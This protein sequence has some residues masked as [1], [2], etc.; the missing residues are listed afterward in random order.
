M[1]AP[2]FDFKKLHPG[3]RAAITFVIVLLLGL[4]GVHGFNSWR[5]Q[6][7]ELLFHESMEVDFNKA[8]SMEVSLLEKKTGLSFRRNSEEGEPQTSRYQT[9]V[10]MPGSLNNYA[11]I[12]ALGWVGVRPWFLNVTVT[13]K[14]DRITEVDRWL[15]LR[16][17]ERDLSA[18]TTI[19]TKRF[20]DDFCNRQHP[21]YFVSYARRIKGADSLSVTTMAEVEPSLRAD[22]F[23]TR[24]ACLTS[25]PECIGPGHLMPEA[26]RV[27]ASDRMEDTGC[28]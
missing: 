26:M 15:V 27:A 11:L 16:V 25:L 18:H 7:A 19:T 9:T 3:K 6:Q 20:E 14:N 1:R 5:S 28:K 13:V 21:D 12:R 22:L 10:S 17:G 8:A 4:A 24:F 2:S 23:Q